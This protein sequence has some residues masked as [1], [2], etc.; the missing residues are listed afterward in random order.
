MCVCMCPRHANNQLH[1]IKN[2][3]IKKFATDT[4]AVVVVVHLTLSAVFQFAPSER[5]K[6]RKIERLKD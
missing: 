1:I 2:Y 3:P 6:E 5:E 4:V